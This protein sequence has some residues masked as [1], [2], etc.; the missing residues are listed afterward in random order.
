MQEIKLTAIVLNS[1]DY[2]EK[3]RLVNL[4][5]LEMGKITAVLKGCKSPKAKLKFAFQPFCF[6]E[7]CLVKRGKYYTIISADLKDSFFDLSKDIDN[8]YLSAAMLEIINI[9][10]NEQEENA[11]LFINTLK[12]LKAICYDN[13]NARLALLKFMV[14]V[15]KIS[16][17]RLQFAKCSVCK[18]DFVNKIYLNLDTGNIVC[19]ACN[20]IGCK[21]MSQNVF[22]IL[23]VVS[24]TEVDRIGSI[25]ANN[26][27]LN[28]ALNLM[29]KNFE[30]RFNRKI[31]SLKNI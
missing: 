25:K 27:V 16:G 12:S 29:S 30:F 20:T 24:G 4:F 7:F 15:L 22:N 5:S 18:N 23:K 2:K 17:Y 14:G 31:N 11:L 28:E 13:V 10:T 1:S 19:G 3:D 6:A 9:V 26:I 8:Y 21:E